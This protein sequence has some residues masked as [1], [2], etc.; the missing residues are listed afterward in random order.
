MENIEKKWN[1]ISNSGNG[2]FEYKLLSKDSI[3]QLN[4]G[5]SKNNSR[6]ILL[7][8]PI[9][10]ERKFIDCAGKYLSLSY[11]SKEKCLIVILNDFSFKDFF[12]DFILS[13]Y[14]RIFKISNPDEYSNQFLAHFQKW[15]SFL[16]IKSF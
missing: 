1:N 4:I 3:P 9:S 6:F 2:E 13:L 5:L 8:L 15:N 7:E 16:E 12:D 14:I 11:F 10:F